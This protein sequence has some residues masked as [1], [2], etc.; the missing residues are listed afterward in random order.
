MRVHPKSL[1]RRLSPE[2]TRALEAAV[3]RAV[4]SRAYEIAV[5]HVLAGL[6][7]DPNGETSRL[8]RE[9]GVSPE[10]VLRTTL[11]ALQRMRCGN[12]GRPVFAESVL[13]WFE[14]AW[15]V[16]SIDHGRATLRPGDLLLELSGRLPRY[17]GETH[18]ELAAL[19]R[20][21]LRERLRESGDETLPTSPRPQPQPPPTPAADGERRDEAPGDGALG[22]ALAQFTISLTD[23]ARD[24]E[25]DPVF[26]RDREIRQVIDVLARRRKNNPILVGEPGVGK[27][28]IVEGLARAIVAGEA[29][30]SLCSCDLRVLD[31]G[32]LAAGA[33]VRGEL[34][35]RLKAVLSEVKASARPIV[36]FIDEAHML[37]G[38]KDGDGELANLLK[39]ELARGEVRTIAATTWSEYKRHFE[40]DAALARRFQPVKIDEPAAETVCLMLRGLRQGFESA[41][42]V[43]IRDE[44]VTAAVALSDRYIAGRYLPDKAVDLL[45]TAAARVKIERE[46]PPEALTRLRSELAAVR[47]ELEGLDRDLGDGRRRGGREALAERVAALEAE[48]AALEA[49][50]RR[51]EAA[52]ADLEAR[53]A[54]LRALPRDAAQAERDAAIDR[55]ER[56]RAA[57]AER[58]GETPLVHAEVDGAA[59]SGVVADWTGIPVG[60]LRAA[61]IAELLDLERAL[62]ERIRG[63][64]EA[65]KVVAEAVQMAHAG[66][67]DP[68]GPVAVLLF[69]G[70]SGVGKTETALALAD[71]VYGGERL[72]T[73][74]NMSE[75]QEKHTVSR[76]IGSPPGYVGYGEG[77]VLSEAVRQRPHSVV[78][79]DEC[80]K[81]D[82]EVMNLFYQV[83]DK[84]ALKDGEGRAIDF[85]HAIVILT[86]NLATD[87]IVALHRRPQPPSAAEVT[88]AIQPILSRHFKPALLGRMTVVPYAPV[89]RPILAEI[90]ALKLAKLAARLERVHGIEVVFE[91]SAVDALV[92]RCAEADSGAR[93]LDHLLRGSLMPALARR[94]LTALAA[95]DLGGLL[96]VGHS[97]VHWSLTLET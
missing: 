38:G 53:Q 20:E 72:M 65:L 8:L 11:R 3:A 25:I 56:A 82:L 55:V 23:R 95:S 92:A 1:I 88:A 29:P 91:A 17:S 79:L 4:S 59:I 86:S 13:T 36:L 73:A 46:A 78:L 41:H 32:L 63:Q 70:P 21:A 18:H 83:F 76:L 87:A 7:D 61:S 10:R 81:A 58:A 85:R 40:R 6:L 30:E 68:D 24:G 9:L 52:I 45:D 51:E 22:E 49:R 35:R 90:T 97:G 42:G 27:T 94:L 44:A 47:F 89:G 60:K 34:E 19:P 14:E 43:V 39:P 28:A 5:E 93:M 84:G 48:E 80:E 75:Y 12:A 77:G 69:V 2:S 57:L 74:I 66:V 33:G 67:R 26:G 62:G 31:L 64:G 50:W 71:L 96:R 15:L 37:M 54:E 16:A